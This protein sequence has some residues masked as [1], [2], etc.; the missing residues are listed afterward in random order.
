MW[1][2][3]QLASLREEVDALLEPLAAT[4]SFYSLIR[5]SLTR[6]SQHQA[7]ADPDSCTWLL[8]PL[9]IYEALS[10]HYQRA[11]P[12]AAA[13]QL[14]KTSAE[15][16]DDIEDADSSKSLSSRCGNAIAVNVAST[17]LILSE[18]AIAGLKAKGVEDYIVIR[19]IDA[20]SSYYTVACIGQHQD[21]ST[22][23]GT[24]ISEDNY[25]NIS[26]MK[27]A[28]TI[29]CACCVGA[30]LATENQQLID[31]FAAFGRNLGISSQIANDIQGITRGND[32]A[33]R[34]ITLPVI[35]ALSQ[36]DSETLK[37]FELAF[38]DPAEPAFNT[39]QIRDLLFSTGAIQYAMVKME[40]YK[41]TALDYLLEVEQ[42]GANIERLKPFL[43]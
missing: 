39:T 34:K 7:V 11:L 20:V 17:L 38:R 24:D 25:I 29:E 42:L 4:N 31:K 43:V 23:A 13:L 18:K 3:I 21:L 33:K 12:A 40:Y 36:A 6:E 10:G 28:S 15:I 14:L 8:L 26:V 30:L 1:Q 32:I 2:E 35:Y 19:V 5:E 22:G 37:Y 16:F 41:Q 9:I 27:S